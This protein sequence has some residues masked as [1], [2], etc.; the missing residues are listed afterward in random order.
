MNKLPSRGGMNGLNYALLAIIS[1]ASLFLPLSVPGFV[2]WVFFAWILLFW[3]AK[4]WAEKQVD[5]L[6]T[7]A[8]HLD[9]PVTDWPV[10]TLDQFKWML[11]NCELRGRE[12]T[13]EEVVDYYIFVLKGAWM[14]VNG[15]PCNNDGFSQLADSRL[16]AGIIELTEPKSD[17]EL[18]EEPRPVQP[19]KT[20]QTRI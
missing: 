7:L 5:K 6:D 15:V 3:A 4:D 13:S 12:V 19:I 14:R 1:A 8:N 17:Y 10:M 11:W 16:S 20:P 18:I 9:A 2:F